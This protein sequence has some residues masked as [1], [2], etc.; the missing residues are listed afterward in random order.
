MRLHA[1]WKRSHLGQ[2]GRVLREPLSEVDTWVA[3]GK[4]QG[5]GPWLHA[6]DDPDAALNT[7]LEF[8]ASHCFVHNNPQS[9]VRGYLAATIVFHKMLAGWQ[10]PTSYCMILAVGRGIDQAHGMSNKKAQVRLP[11]TWAM[12]SQGRRV[13]ASMVD[14][15]DVMWLGL[16]MTYFLFVQSVRVV[17]IHQRSGPP[18]ILPDEE[19]SH[20][21]S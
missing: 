6:L 16:A 21:F 12:L 7:L 3:E 20:F 18:R 4:A 13:V 10:Q 2:S 5:K 1:W 17:G 9:T 11:L 8:M 15:G 19:L 14:G